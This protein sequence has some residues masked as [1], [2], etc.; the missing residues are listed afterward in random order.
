MRRIVEPG[1]GKAP[2]P[3]HG[4][5]R[6]LE[7]LADLE[8]RQP[9]EELEL[10][11]ATS[12]RIESG[13]KEQFG[14]GSATGIGLRN[15]Y[16]YYATPTSIVRYK[17]PAGELKPAGEVETVALDLPERR[18]HSDKGLAFDGK[19]GV[20]VDFGSPSN[21]C[22]QPDRQPNVPGQ[23]PCPLLDTYAG[24]IRF[25]ENKLGQKPADGHRYS[26]GMRQEVG[27][28]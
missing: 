21:A 27:L 8:R 14:Q 25:D 26:T 10:D 23:D 17:L 28:T 7:H 5:G 19:G 2:I 6:K 24:I 1:A 4:R 12:A 15:G 18:Q 13:E 22:Q 20:Y 16:I 9:S 3:F 11:D